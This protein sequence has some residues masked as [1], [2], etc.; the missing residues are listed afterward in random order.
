MP[1]INVESRSLY[2]QEQGQG[3]ALVLVPGLGMDSRGWQPVAGRLSETRRVICWDPPGS[4]QGG[5]A[6]EYLSIQ[7]LAG[8]L[9]GLVRE[10]ELE[11]PAL[12]GAS[13]GGLVVLA[14]AAQ[15][16]DL[17]AKVVVSNLGPRLPGAVAHRLRL[18]QRMRQEGVNPEIRIR[19]QLQWTIPPELFENQLLITEL[20]A[21]G[22]ADPLAQSDQDYSRQV[23]A[24]MGFNAAS[25]APLVNCPALVLT[26]ADDL[27]IP[28]GYCQDL[29]GLLPQGSLVVL[30]GGGHSPFLFQPRRFARA[31]MTFLEA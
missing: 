16:P 7:Y 27:M 24:V 30:Q 11:A 23:A 9:A 1:T 2:Y 3:Q 8:M 18:W 14:A 5:L 26:A 17:A 12:V 20:A 4:G 29:A 21:Q 19:S 28:P 22:L 31:V 15:Y 10:L 6:P 25:C 13:M